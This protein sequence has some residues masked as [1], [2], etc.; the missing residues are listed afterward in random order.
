MFS[1]R[2]ALVTP[3][4][5]QI[6][7]FSPVNS[8]LSQSEFGTTVTATCPLGKVRTGSLSRNFLPSIRLSVWMNWLQP[9]I[10]AAG[11]ASHSS[12]SSGEPVGMPFLRVAVLTHASATS[13]I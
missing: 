6:S 13:R 9:S 10:S 2:L 4:C 11:P 5:I 1:A 12:P 3:G 8:T 7:A